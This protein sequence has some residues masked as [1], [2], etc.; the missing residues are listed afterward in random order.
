MLLLKAEPMN[1][2]FNSFGYLRIPAF[3]TPAEMAGIGREFPLDMPGLKACCADS[4]EHLISLIEHP[5]VTALIEDVMGPSW[6]YKGSDGNY[7]TD[8]T[9]WHRDYFVKTPTCKLLTYLDPTTLDVIPGSHFVEGPF[10]K[11]LNAAL[12]WP[13]GAGFNKMMDPPPPFTR[14]ATAPGDVIVFS[15]N[16]V[17]RT[18]EPGRRRRLLG[19]HF[20]AEFTPEIA[21]LTMIEMRTFAVPTCY[22]PCVKRGPRTA[23]FMDLRNEVG[24]N[25]SGIYEKQSDESI[26]FA[27][28]WM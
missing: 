7:F 15:H 26:A 20:A 24:G 10:S 9:P 5:K 1:H 19:L 8:S 16:L 4:N 14:L 22:G 3:F 11:H 18:V 2:F 12:R 23:P 28:R 17:H 13:E 21:E 25:F 27:R 6:L